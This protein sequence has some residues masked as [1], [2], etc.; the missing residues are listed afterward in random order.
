MRFCS[1]FILIDGRQI[2]KDRHLYW[3]LNYG[4]AVNN[5]AESINKQVELTDPFAVD[6]KP[7]ISLQ[8]SISLKKKKKVVILRVLVPVFF[9]FN[10]LL[11]HCRF[12]YSNCCEGCRTVTDDGSSTAI[13]N[14][15]TCSLTTKANSRFQSFF[16]INIKW[17]LC[18]LQSVSFFFYYYFFFWILTQRSQS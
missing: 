17:R 7:T 11:F 14:R 10:W 2:G 6:L 18:Y 13:S 9:S 1:Q 4:V 3:Y 8:I 15:R 12:F 16:L 5:T